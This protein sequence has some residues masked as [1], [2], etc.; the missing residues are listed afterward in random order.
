MS[1]SSERRELAVGLRH[2]EMRHR[3]YAQEL[4]RLVQIGDARSDVEALA[5][6]IALTFQ[7]VDKAHRDRNAVKY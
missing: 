6:A 5:A 2:L 3:L 7:R 4:G 1:S